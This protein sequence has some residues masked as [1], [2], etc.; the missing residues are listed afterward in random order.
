M[1]INV[2]YKSFL[3]DFMSCVIDSIHFHLYLSMGVTLHNIPS[4]KHHV[5]H[6]SLWYQ[7]SKK[8]ID[9]AGRGLPDLGSTCTGLDGW[10]FSLTIA[11]AFLRTQVSLSSC[12]PT[13]SR[14]ESPRHVGGVVGVG[15]VTY[16]M[17]VQEIGMS[18]VDVTGFHGHKIADELIFQ[19]PVTFLIHQ[20]QPS[21]SGL[22]NKL[23]SIDKTSFESC[24]TSW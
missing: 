13:N 24:L 5:D 18:R 6:A 2:G 4:Q 8:R 9:H 3:G 23:I 22:L 15:Q 17:A 1:V 19:V 11:I 14:W 7:P 10:Y 20:T 16:A 21:W 12:S